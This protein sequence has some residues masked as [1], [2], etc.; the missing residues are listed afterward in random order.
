MWANSVSREVAPR[1][2]S[3][4]TPEGAEVVASDRGGRATRGTWSE[5]GVARGA[6]LGVNGSV[7][8]EEAGGRYARPLG[9]QANTADK[10]RNATQ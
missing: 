2:L 5:E 6:K 10:L 1:T 9:C 3:A 7:G 4:A 8:P